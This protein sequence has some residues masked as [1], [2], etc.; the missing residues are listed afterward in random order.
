MFRSMRNWRPVRCDGGGF[1]CRVLG[2]DQRR[3]LRSLPS[4]RHADVERKLYLTTKFLVL[5]P[6]G[7]T[8]RVKD[9]GSF[10]QYASTLRKTAWQ[11]L[12][13][14][15]KLLTIASKMK[16]NIASHWISCYKQV[17]CISAI[18][19]CVCTATQPAVK[20]SHENIYFHAAQMFS[21]L[22]YEVWWSQPLDIEYYC[23]FV[24]FR[25]STMLI[26]GTIG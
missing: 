24:M 14:W 26:P 22:R 11:V 7:F 17:S 2:S 1:G 16:K 13:T 3:P 15:N 19:G 12:S 5:P 4:T 20:K 23:Y 6:S 8:R 10:E 25:D 9:K 18:T 21:I